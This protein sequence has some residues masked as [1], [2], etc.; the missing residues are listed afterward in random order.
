MPEQQRR[1]EYNPDMPMLGGALEK[2]CLMAIVRLSNLGDGM[3]RE[4][5]AQTVTFRDESGGNLWAQCPLSGRQIELTKTHDQ[6]GHT[7]HT[8]R[9]SEQLRCQFNTF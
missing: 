7:V 4:V 1:Q 6:Q 3:A 9:Q 2:G 8:L 5:L